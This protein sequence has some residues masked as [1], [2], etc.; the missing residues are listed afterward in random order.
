MFEEEEVD[1]AANA[2]AT[3]AA[4]NQD[5]AQLP[6]KAQVDAQAATARDNTTRLNEVL[7][8]LPDDSPVKAFIQEA[9]AIIAKLKVSLVKVFV[10][11]NQQ[12][13][14]DSLK[15]L[16]APVLDL[17]RKAVSAVIG[18]LK[19]IY[20]K[21]S[22]VLAKFD[23]IVE[24]LIELPDLV[25]AMEDFVDAVTYDKA[26]NIAQ[27]ISTVAVFASK[28]WEEL[29]KILHLV[30][31]VLMGFAAMDSITIQGN[32]FPKS[33]LDKLMTDVGVFKEDLNA[34]YIAKIPSAVQAKLPSRQATLPG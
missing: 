1:E 25:G 9:E 16:P 2:A 4:A 28:G 11:V 26:R 24:L 23:G 3:Q 17:L 5:A 29:G 21:V 34:R 31:H 10:V 19:T 15:Q 20:D 18:F 27:Q 13:I 30:A 14:Q 12:N 22:A 8:E 33:A 6:T 32:A 7:A